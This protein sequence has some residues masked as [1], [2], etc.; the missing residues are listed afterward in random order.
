[1]LFLAACAAANFK[2]YQVEVWA[3]FLAA[4]AAANIQTIDQA[5][6]R[7][8][9]AA[10]A[11]ANKMGDEINNLDSFLEL[12]NDKYLIFKEQERYRARHPS[13]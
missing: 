11:A 9:L 5:P 10:C 12:I 3:D 1:M 7:R 2:D 13:F 8:F 6:L 4:C